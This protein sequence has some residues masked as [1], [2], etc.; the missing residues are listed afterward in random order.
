MSGADCHR[1]SELAAWLVGSAQT[2]DAVGQIVAAAQR[3][4]GHTVTDHM[5][6][7]SFLS[8][9]IEVP[10]ARACTLI[11]AEVR[12]AAGAGSARIEAVGAASQTA[13]CFQLQRGS[14]A[15]AAA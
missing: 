14:W 15:V 13:L 10:A 2:A 9:H 8:V 3:A 7:E 5:A 4:V 1:Y 11:V 6:A 12:I